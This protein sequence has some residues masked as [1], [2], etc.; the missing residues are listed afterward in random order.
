M[1][2]NKSVSLIILLLFI[3]PACNSNSPPENINEKKMVAQNTQANRQTIA[4]L[5]AILKPY[6]I[7]EEMGGGRVTRRYHG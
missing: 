3:I 1:L 6:W 7:P 4:E 2:I 5:R